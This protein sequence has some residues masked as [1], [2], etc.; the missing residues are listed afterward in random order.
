MKDASPS[1]FLL[2]DT[3]QRHALQNPLA[4]LKL[5]PVDE[6]RD[7]LDTAF[8]PFLLW[9]RKW[10][11]YSRGNCPLPTPPHLSSFYQT[12]EP[13]MQANP[14]TDWFGAR[15]GSGMP[16]SLRHFDDEPAAITL[17]LLETAV[18][19]LNGLVDVRNAGE[20]MRTGRGRI[21]AQRL[22]TGP[23]LHCAFYQTG[24]GSSSLM[25]AVAV[26]KC[27]DPAHVNYRHVLYCLGSCCG[28][29]RHRISAFTRSF[30]ISAETDCHPLAHIQDG[31]D[32]LEAI[33]VLPYQSKFF[34]VST[35]LTEWDRLNLVRSQYD[36][37]P[38]WLPLAVLENGSE[39]FGPDVEAVLGMINSSEITSGMVKRIQEVP[40]FPLSLSP[41]ESS[42]IEE[43]GPVLL[44]GRSGTGKTTCALLRFWARNQVFRRLWLQRFHASDKEVDG[45]QIQLYNAVFLTLSPMLCR[46][47]AKYYHSLEART[48]AH[49]DRLFDTTDSSS[50]SS[51]PSNVHQSKTRDFEK[52]QK[53]VDELLDKEDNELEAELRDE[54]PFGEDPASGLPSNFS[55]QKDC[56]FP[57]FVTLHQ[58]LYM[59]DGT[60]YR[61]FFSRDAAGNIMAVSASPASWHGEVRTTIKVNVYADS[62]VFRLPEGSKLQWQQADSFEI[63]YDFFASD[64][65]PMLGPCKDHPS[66]V[67]AVIMNYY[68]G[69]QIIRGKR[70]DKRKGGVYDQM[71][72]R[73]EDIKRTL[74]A[75]DIQDVV[76]YISDSINSVGYRGVPVHALTV[77]E[78]QDF[79]P[80]TL[81]LFMRC[82]QRDDGY[83]FCGDSCQTIARGINFRFSDLR[84]LFFC[85]E[86]RSL[87]KRLFPEIKQLTVNYRSH[88]SLLHLGH[89]IVHVL[90]SLFPNTIDKLQ[91][92]SG[93]RSGPKPLLFHVSTPEELFFLIQG[94]NTSQDLQFGANQ[95]IIVRSQRAKERL[96]SILNHSLVLT[97][98]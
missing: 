79:S 3:L 53:A 78:V 35:A 40:G 44:I 63:D 22:M 67:W 8:E 38:V 87:K 30:A 43:S 70:N 41:Q 58:F 28:S 27:I 94:Q 98:F 4:L 77:D 65:F 1:V 73:Y 48:S 64:I 29:P 95:V 54:D 9:M 11:S 90:E 18:A 84:H 82:C 37:K 20:G 97:V 56:S 51:L 57:M 34:S 45:V 36:Q 59:V 71:Y 32:H 85:S 61:P 14:L 47:I 62:K 13:W 7:S 96:P 92:D 49:L 69:D 83:F 6:V 93:V 42:L 23:F 10:A 74:G 16:L 86:N 39:I 33:P 68:K 91:L 60:L 76:H 88:T 31:Q 19:F 66:R 81:R 52:D 5:V 80:A 12:W 25:W 21:V 72:H 15:L 89:S 24:S 2:A 46:S 50:S 26:E 75:Y 17:G 55:L